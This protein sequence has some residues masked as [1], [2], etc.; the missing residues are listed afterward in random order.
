MLEACCRVLNPG[1]LLVVDNLF[2]SGKVLE[3][4]PEE[5]K[6]YSNGVS[7]LK[8]FNQAIAKHDTFECTFLPLSDGVLV[9][10]RTGKEGT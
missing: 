8:A 2:Y 6:K 1:G 4:K 7:L 3:M 10:E 9:A 5:K